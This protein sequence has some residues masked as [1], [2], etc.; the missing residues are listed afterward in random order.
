MFSF[1]QKQASFKDI[2]IDKLLDA[3][4]TFIAPTSKLETKIE[5]FFDLNPNMKLKFVNY[6]TSKTPSLAADESSE[7]TLYQCIEIGQENSVCSDFWSQI[8]LLHKIKEDIIQ[9]KEN[10]INEKKEL[11][12]YRWGL[13]VEIEKLQEQINKTL[14]IIT[15]SEEDDGELELD[16]SLETVIKKAK[17]RPLIDLTDQLW[18]ILKC[19]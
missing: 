3:H 13:G 16:H 14:E 17:N 15:V 19:K 6:S 12:V 9:Y 11:P 8:Y 1:F 18:D 2:S 5:T 10:S 7:V 4:F